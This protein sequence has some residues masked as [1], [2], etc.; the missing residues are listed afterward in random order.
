MSFE[1][2]LLNLTNWLGN[3]IMPTLAGLLFAVAIVRYAKGYPWN[4]SMWAAVAALCVS[5]LLRALET[6]TSQAAWNDPDLIW[7]TLH[8]RSKNRRSVHCSLMPRYSR[9]EG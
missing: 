7:I 3:V 4:Y 9:D 6:V 1:N 2:G 8:C 5:G